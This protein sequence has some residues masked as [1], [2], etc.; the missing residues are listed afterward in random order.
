MRRSPHAPAHCARSCARQ[1][2]LLDGGGDVA[3]AETAQDVVYLMAMCH[4]LTCV[5]PLAWLLVMA[6]P[7]VAASWLWRNVVSPWIFTPREGE[8][9]GPEARGARRGKAERRAGKAT[10]QRR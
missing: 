2:E 4:V 10:P 1:G 8:D 6:I 5:S 7:G 9:G 3:K